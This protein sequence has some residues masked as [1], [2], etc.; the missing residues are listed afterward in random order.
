MFTT[1]V[2]ALVGIILMAKSWIVAS[3]DVTLVV[4]GRKELIVPAGG[5]LLGCLA[6]SEI[7]VSSACG[8]GGTCALCVV[9]VLQGGG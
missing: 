2:L 6:D 4:N 9:K 1:V 7:F 5:K 8:G 3:G